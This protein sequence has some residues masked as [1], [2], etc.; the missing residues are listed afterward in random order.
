MQVY[1]YTALRPSRTVLVFFSQIKTAEGVIQPTDLQDGCRGHPGI[2]CIHQL[3]QCEGLWSSQPWQVADGAVKRFFTPC[4]CGNSLSRYNHQRFTRLKGRLTNLLRVTDCT[5]TCLVQGVSELETS[6]V[7]WGNDVIFWA[8]ILDLPSNA[9]LG[10][11]KTSRQNS[12]HPY[13]SR[14]LQHLGS[15]LVLAHAGTTAPARALL[16][17]DL[18]LSFLI[19]LYNL[20][21]QTCKYKK[22]AESKTS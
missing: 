17:I 13:G 20:N 6:A 9:I 14:L 11:R 2:S 10:D 22:W 4:I 3:L 18:Q 1:G 12:S 16:T 8:L 21:F 15:L 5:E 7:L 19:A